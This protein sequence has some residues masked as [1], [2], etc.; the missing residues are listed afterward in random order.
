MSQSCGCHAHQS[1]GCSAEPLSCYEKNVDKCLY[2][3]QFIGFNVTGPQWVKQEIPV[4]RCQ[5]IVGCDDREDCK[6][7]SGLKFGEAV[8]PFYL[9]FERCKLKDLVPHKKKEHCCDKSVRK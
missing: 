6:S 5:T 1:C 2:A 3:Y 4:P 7:K 9:Q 8:A